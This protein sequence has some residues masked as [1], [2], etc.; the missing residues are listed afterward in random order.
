MSV[1]FSEGFVGLRGQNNQ[2][3]NTVVTFA[4]LGFD[5]TFFS[6]V[7]ATGE[8]IGSGAQGNDVAGTL[9]LRRGAEVL[10]I[11]GRI[12]WQLKEQGDLKLFGFLPNSNI[13]DIAL[14]MP[15]GT[16]LPAGIQMKDVQDLVPGSDVYVT[17]GGESTYYISGASNFGVSKFGISLSDIKPL[18]SAPRGIDTG[19]DVGGS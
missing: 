17:T 8:F 5:A 7:S 16:T 15:S 19:E 14:S 11:D 13:A 12:G 3:A 1:P 18:T 10:D 4:D 6:Q 2:D 9:R